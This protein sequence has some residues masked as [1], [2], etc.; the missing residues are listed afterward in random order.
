MLN[1]GP[2]LITKSEM[3]MQHTF[4]R[5]LMVG[6]ANT[7]VGV[8]I[9][10]LLLHLLHMNYWWST[11]IGNSVGILVSFYLNRSFT[12]RNKEQAWKTFPRFLAV[13][14]LS[15]FLAYGIGLAAAKKLFLYLPLPA[16]WMESGAVLF[17]AGLY[18]LLNY[19]GHRLFTFQR[20][21]R[22]LPQ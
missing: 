17:G 7:I 3:T 18:T 19:A 15:Y 16:Q 21:K 8:G 9:T 13:T 2:K 6:V 5:F 20:A 22:S 4:I 12:F 14:L 1:E 11:F 10:L